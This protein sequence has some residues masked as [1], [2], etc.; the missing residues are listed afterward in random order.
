MLEPTCLLPPQSSI[1]ASEP[2]DEVETHCPAP[3]CAFVPSRACESQMQMAPRRI[4]RWPSCLVSQAGSGAAPSPSLIQ[5]A[6]G[7]QV[8]PRFEKRRTSPQLPVAVAAWV[9]SG[10]RLMLCVGRPG[11][12]GPAFQCEPATPDGG[13]WAVLGC[14]IVKAAFRKK[15]SSE[16][17]A[18]PASWRQGPRAPGPGRRRGP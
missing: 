7:L 8:W 13:S 1:A 9:A 2:G 16:P 6:I 12:K 17:L 11:C 10:V 15:K 18:E 3:T 5:V 4:S 14:S